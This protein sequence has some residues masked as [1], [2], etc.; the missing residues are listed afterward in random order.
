MNRL[1]RVLA[2]L[3]RRAAGLLPADRGAWAEAAWAEAAEVPDGRRRLAWLAGGLWMAARQARLV[4]RAGCWLVFAVV[5]AAMVLAGWPGAGDNPATLINRVDVIAIVVMLAGLPWAV[6]RFAGPAGDGRLTRVVRA[7]GYA[8]ILALALTKANAERFGNAPPYGSLSPS[9]LWAG[10]IVFL[11]AM[12]GYAGWILTVTARRPPAAPATVA[13]GTAAGATAGLAMYARGSLH[14]TGPGLAGLS[15][16]ATVLTWAVLLSAPVLAGLASARRTSGHGSQPLPADARA[17]QGLAAGLCAGAAAALSVSVLG[18]AMI[19]FLPHAPALFS[20]AFPVRHLA[21][22][23]LHRYEAGV[24]Q[25]AADYLFALL[26]FPLIGA[27]LGAWGGL[28]TI[29]RPGQG[30]GGDG[31]SPAPVPVPP[32]PG[33]GRQ[34]AVTTRPLAGVT[35][36]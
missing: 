24:S 14:L 27:G 16:A 19:A 23:A 9:L 33:S 4:R 2:E 7:G 11:V 34:I 6:R 26:L 20:W 30:P 15:D 5:A 17:R 8:A 32:P 28:A 35:E 22:G 1:S 29:S 10:E 3:L 31:G 13:I 25:D 12:A 21:G 36:R 18:T